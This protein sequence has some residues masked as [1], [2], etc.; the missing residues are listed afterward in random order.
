[1]LN[2]KGFTILEILVAAAIS[3]MIFLASWQN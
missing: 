2:N 3:L 1:M